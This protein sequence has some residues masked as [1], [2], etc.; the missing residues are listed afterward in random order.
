MLKNLPALLIIHGLLFNGYS[1]VAPSSSAANPVTPAKP[2]PQ[3]IKPFDRAKPPK[4]TQT[5]VKLKP[6]ELAKLV[7][8][9]V[10][11][12]F[13]IDR[14]QL[15]TAIDH[16]LRYIRTGTA[17]KKYPIAGFSR[18]RVELSLVRFRQL[19]ESAPNA[20]ALNQAVLREFDLYKS[21]GLDGKG[22]VHFTGYFEP[23]FPASRDRTEKFKYPLYRLPPDFLTW[24]TP[25]PTRVELE[26]GKLK[27]LEL[28]WLN[29]RF[30]AFLIH[31]QGSAR[32][33]LA[34]KQVMTVGY[35][36]KTDRP[37]NSIGKE[38]VKD[39]KMRLE[40]VTLQRLIAYFQQKPQELDG[41]LN[42][43]DS[44]VFFRDTMGQAAT[45]SIGSP[46]T[47][48]R[49][50]ATDKSI[51]PPGSIALIRTTLPFADKSK[52][53]LLVS[54]PVSRFVLDQ[55]T[56]G[57]ITGAG[58]VDVFMGTGQSAQDRA[59][60]MNTDGELYYLLLK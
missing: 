49:S 10:D 19:V 23:V 15:L 43:N 60:L 39:G 53:N 4:P 36:G 17:A 48:E 34:D 16:S 33:Q 8:L 45:G 26:R 38:L 59:G 24:K 11:D 2:T 42:R 56:G 32:L 3:P 1:S 41:Y 30:Q 25:H 35:A 54:R 29:D 50:I 9:P 20:M 52:N 55:D 13:G 7:N 12:L 5:L 57:A 14:T 58:R 46:V 40:D 44:Y 51:F 28:V 27:G 18:D 6:Q 37:Y 31:V 22:T 21:V 47:A